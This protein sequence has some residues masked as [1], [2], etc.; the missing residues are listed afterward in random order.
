MISLREHKLS[1]GSMRL[2]TALLTNHQS[3]QD[4]DLAATALS[5]EWLTTLFELIKNGRVVLSSLNLQFNP[6]IGKSFADDLLALV[7]D[8][9]VII[10]DNWSAHTGAR[11]SYRCLP[12][13][14]S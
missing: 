4:L 5:R 2:L 12:A 13:S 3:I 11:C 1:R 10:H 8:Y 14:V 9:D 7:K 6:S